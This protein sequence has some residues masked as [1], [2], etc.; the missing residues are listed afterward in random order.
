[1]SFAFSLPLPFHRDIYISLWFQVHTGDGLPE[2]LCVQCVLQVSRAFNF[3][4]VCQRSDANLR[5]VYLD[6][7]ATSSL[8]IDTPSECEATT[9]QQIP[10]NEA[11][12]MPN[13]GM[14]NY[15]DVNGTNSKCLFVVRNMSLLNR[16][17]DQM[18]MGM[19]A[20]DEIL[21]VESDIEDNHQTRQDE[22][23]GISDSNPTDINNLVSTLHIQANVENDFG[24]FVRIFRVNLFLT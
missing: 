20:S 13:Q 6:S 9:K 15:P 21:D 22:D 4:Q 18:L 24:N 7:L 12:R 3:K 17:S 10:S 8:P 16:S 1:M 14:M 2:T 11:D 19:S 23:I 5:Q